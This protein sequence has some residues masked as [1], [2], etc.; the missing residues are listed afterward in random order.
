VRTA[1][2]LLGACRALA[3]EDF[4]WRPPPYEYEDVLA[5]IDILWGHPGLREGIDAGATADDILEGVDAELA[6]FTEEIQ[7]YLLYE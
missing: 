2:A 5:P 6:M 7:P 4:D 1:V 3:P